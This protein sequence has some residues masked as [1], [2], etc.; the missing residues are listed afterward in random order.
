MKK[1]LG[2]W[3]IFELV[4]GLIPILTPLWYR[5]C[6]SNFK[7]RRVIK[8]GNDYTWRDAFERIIVILLSA[9]FVKWGWNTLAPYINCPTF[10][11]AEVGAMYIGLDSLLDLIKRKVN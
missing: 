9:L 7:R 1:K 11:Y 8:M 2:F 4:G 3:D 6:T 10:T 5:S